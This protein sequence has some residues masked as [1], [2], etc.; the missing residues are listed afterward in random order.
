MS[1]VGSGPYAIPAGGQVA[2][3]FAAGS[4]LANL[5]TATTGLVSTAEGDEPAGDAAT[6]EV[7]PN[8][9]S[10]RASLSFALG[11]AQTVRLTVVDVL[12]SGFTRG[13]EVAVVTDGMRAA[14]AHTAT[15]DT[16]ALPS[17]VYVARLA[18]GAQTVTRR[19]M[20]AR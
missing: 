5:R 1:V 18:A 14:G 8:P 9:A 6:P 13:R 10:A 11:V 20:V 4:S 7:A 16:Q 17:G 19:F 12:R 3:S 15:V 2:V